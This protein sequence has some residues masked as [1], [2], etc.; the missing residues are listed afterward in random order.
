MSAHIVREKD[1][2]G[3]LCLIVGHE[4][5]DPSTL[6]YTSLK[7]GSLAACVKK[8]FYRIVVILSPGPPPCEKL[9]TWCAITPVQA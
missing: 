7:T 6:A 2:I 1:P 8:M 5:K 9:A 3:A 4:F